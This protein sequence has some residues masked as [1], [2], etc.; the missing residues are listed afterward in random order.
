[1]GDD[2]DDLNF[3]NWKN[4]EICLCTHKM[5]LIIEK[6]RTKF[7]PITEK[8]K[9]SEHKCVKGSQFSKKQNLKLKFAFRKYAKYAYIWP[10]WICWWENIC[11]VLLMAKKAFADGRRPKAK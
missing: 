10:D 5:E 7:Y 6:D 11:F 1:M 9:T 8:Y 4:Q 2:D 3:E